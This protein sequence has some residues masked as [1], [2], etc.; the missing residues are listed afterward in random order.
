VEQ[1]QDL[2][3]FLVLL[4]PAAADAQAPLGWQPGLPAAASR[5]DLRGPDPLLLLLVSVRQL[6]LLVS[7][8]QQ[9]LA[10]A[11]LL[12]LLLLLVLHPA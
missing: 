9:G 11:Q 7:A 8:Q 3:Q 2:Q 1:Q 4:P 6:L 12:L 10:Q 5:P